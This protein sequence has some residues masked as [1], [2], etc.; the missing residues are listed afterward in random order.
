VLGYVLRKLDFETAPIVL[1]LVLAPMMELSLRQSL[2]MSGGSY[3]IFITRP[4]SVILLA[5][6]LILVVLALRPLISRTLDWRSRLAV[7]T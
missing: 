5:V 6:G 4:I 3:A 1:G 7:D 2:A